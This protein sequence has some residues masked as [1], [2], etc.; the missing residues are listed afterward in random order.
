MFNELTGKK[1]NESVDSSEYGLYITRQS[2]STGPNTVKEIR[3]EQKAILFSPIGSYTIQQR[4]TF[5]K[6]QNCIQ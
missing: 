2:P 6:H 1:L 5:T 4:L 3:A